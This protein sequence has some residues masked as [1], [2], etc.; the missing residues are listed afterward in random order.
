MAEKELSL[1]AVVNEDI[2]YLQNELDRKYGRFA[3]YITIEADRTSGEFNGMYSLIMVTK[4]KETSLCYGPI[5]EINAALKAMC[6]FCEANF[7]RN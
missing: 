4:E 7:R 2:A 5:T 6:A 3:P 1:R